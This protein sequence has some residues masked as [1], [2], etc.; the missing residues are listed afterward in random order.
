MYCLHTRGIQLVITNTL[1]YQFLALKS[2]IKDLIDIV[3]DWEKNQGLMS[4][5]IERKNIAFIKS[6][7][8]NT[9][10]LK[11]SFSPHRYSSYI[12]ALLNSW[13]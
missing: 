5:L 3:L 2:L 4:T 1:V 8:R 12:D 7:N 11:I 13:N 9:L 10:E 6:T